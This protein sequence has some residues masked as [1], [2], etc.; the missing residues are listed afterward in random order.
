MEWALGTPSLEAV[1]ALRREVMAYLRRHAEP[2]SDFAGAAVVVAE[3]LSNAFEHAPG[4]AWVRT[5]WTDERPRLEIHALGEG[6]ALDP[7]LPDPSAERGRGLFLV[8]AIADELEVAAKPRK[9]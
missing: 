4:P 3:L 2:D 6:F 9:G 5:S 1:A 7:A 8:N